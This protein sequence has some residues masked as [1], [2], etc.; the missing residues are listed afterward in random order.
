MGTN[1]E[2]EA[3][4]RCAMSS[5]MATTGGDHG[6]NPFDGDRIELSDDELRSASRHVVA[7]GNIK[8]RLN[9][10]VRGLTYGR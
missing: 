1:D 7:L 9:E 10:W 3:C 5:A 8:R 4:G 2:A 6:T